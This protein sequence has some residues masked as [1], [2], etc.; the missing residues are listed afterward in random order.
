MEVTYLVEY[1]QTKKAQLLE[2]GECPIKGKPERASGELA[3][4]TN[5]DSSQKNAPTSKFQIVGPG[6]ES[7]CVRMWDAAG[8]RRMCSDVLCAALFVSHN[9]MLNV[10]GLL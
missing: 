5:P 10:D 8:A 6:L 9:L 1:K 4:I 3:D 7:H 2:S